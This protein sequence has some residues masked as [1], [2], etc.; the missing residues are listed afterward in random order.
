MPGGYTGNAQVL[1][2]ALN[3]PLKANMVNH[4]SEHIYGKVIDLS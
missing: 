3:K 1:D 4:V 2:V